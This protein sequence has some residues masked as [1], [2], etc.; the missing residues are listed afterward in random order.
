MAVDEGL[1]LD[2][3]FAWQ[4]A[5][6]PDALAIQSGARTLTYA[7]LDARAGRLAH[8]LTVLGVGPEVVVALCLPR[9]IEMV[10]GILGV[11]K[12]GGAYL[13]LD[14]THPILRLGTVLDETAAAVVVASEAMLDELPVGRGQLVLEEGSFTDG[15]VA[16]P[17][18]NARADGLAYVIATSGSTGK[19]KAVAVSHAGVV[20]L[21]RWQ[22]ETYAITAADRLTL[23]S[24]PAFDA[25]VWELWQALSAG[26]SLH[27]VSDELRD[28]PREL[29]AWLAAEKITVS[30]LPTPLAA[31]IVAEAPPPDLGLRV[32]TTAGDVLHQAPPTARPYRFDNLYG[33][34]ETSVCTTTATVTAGSVGRPPIGRPIAGTRVYL[35]DDRF[36]PTPPGVAGQLAVGGRSLARGYLGRPDLT[37][38][39]FVPDPFGKAPGERLYLTGDLVKGRDDRQL[40]FIG[41]ADGQVKI[42]GFRVELG[43]IEATL[44]RQPTVREAA[45]VLREDRPGDLKLVAYV[46]G[47]KGAEA[48]VNE[49]RAVLAKTLPDYMVPAAFVQLGALPRTAHGK[50][51]RAALPS[52]ERTTTTRDRP[53]VGP[54]NPV[55]QTLAEVW[56][57]TL[58]IAVAELD[59]DDNFFERGGD[60]I[61]AIQVVSRAVL[62][63]VQVTAKQIFAYPTI[64]GLAAVAGTSAGVSADQGPATGRVGFAPIQRWFLELG[65]PEPDHYNQAVLLEI[66]RPFTV[67]AL[68]AAVRALVAR[69]DALRLRVRKDG[70]TWVQ[71]YAQMTEAAS[72]ARVDHSAVPAA[73]L[74]AAVDRTVN[75]LQ[76]SLDLAHGPI[77]RFARI[78]RGATLSPLLLVCVHHIAVDGVS[79]RVILD[80]LE[81][82]LRGE[83]LAAKTSSFQA[84]TTKLGE[85]AQ[86]PALEAELAHWKGVARADAAALPVD[87]VAKPGSAG[88]AARVAVALDADETRAFLREIPAARLQPAEVLVGAVASAIARWAG[89]GAVQLDVEGHGRE[90]LFEDVDLS[91]TVGW[92]TSSHP[93]RIDVP[94]DPGALLAAVRGCLKVAPRGGLGY[95]LLRYLGRPEVAREM[96]ALAPSQISLNYLG[97]LDAVVPEGAAL[98]PVREPPRGA[99]S[100]ETPRPHLLDVTASVLDGKLQVSFGYHPAAHRAETITKLAA[101][102]LAALRTLIDRC[103]AGGADALTP[104]DF[105]LAQLDQGALDRLLDEED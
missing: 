28:A 81:K 51:D 104:G 44:T 67:E 2:G 30:W 102:T 56:A 98:V 86:S 36:G 3:L 5:K 26:A 40:E 8:E 62:A 52:P 88:G 96:A 63:G 85:L 83:T 60:S 42:R 70:G 97:Q 105:P 101:D 17:R 50:V 6:T 78:D 84:W 68:E 1:C 71:A 46:V 25:V 73:D 89:R 14:P 22:V 33:P 9:S 31:L 99:Q 57:T 103:K 19:P 7:E 65:S 13:P 35:I 43:E 92:F 79:W 16:P 32:L 82:T 93:I 64:A 74:A 41:R 37:A 58:G 10:V 95:G 61:L 66:R 87:G 12:A 90:D 94:A 48:D 69:H 49:L 45:V 23:V 80:D 54:R 4:V 18:S 29:L 39:R 27:V 75:G 15:P 76:A 24:Q 100:D 34:T 59:V 72:L 47:Q 11:L 38:E 20:A 91:Q 55:E 53:R 77:V 21:A